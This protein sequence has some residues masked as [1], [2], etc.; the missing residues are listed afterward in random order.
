MFGNPLTFD[1][2]EATLLLN[3]FTYWYFRK[4][5][6]VMDLRL[7]EYLIYLSA[8]VLLTVWVGR[9]LHRNG[10]RFLVDVMEDEPLADSVNRLLLVG[11]YL[12]NFG[13]AALLVNPSGGVGSPAD[14]VQTL[15]TQL[16]VV[17]LILGTLHLGN[18]F[19]LNRL[20]RNQQA[21]AYARWYHEQVDAKSIPTTET[22]GG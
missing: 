13:V 3:T 5:V 14:M 12:V 4:E 16:G 15:A 2:K 20:R 11:F 18:V 9:T 1:V 19:V 10:R 7:I 22:S 8:S 17:L 21:R 6:V